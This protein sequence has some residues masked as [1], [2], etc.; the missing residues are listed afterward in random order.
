MSINNYLLLKVSVLEQVSSNEACRIADDILTVI[1]DPPP[2]SPI[3]QPMITPTPT[4]T[5]QPLGSV[6]YLNGMSIP[7]SNSSIGTVSANGITLTGLGGTILSY[8]AKSGVFTMST[9]SIRSG[10]PTSSTELVKLVFVDAY[11]NDPFR[12][13]INGINYNASF[14]NGT[15]YI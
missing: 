2:A 13:N 15:I 6:T 5:S 7:G 14:T 10:T 8:N 12:I 3:P 9:L 1:C 4:P 11:M